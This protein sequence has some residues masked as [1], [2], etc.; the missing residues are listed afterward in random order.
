[1]KLLSKILGIAGKLGIG[2]IWKPVINIVV[3]ALLCLLVWWGVNAAWNGVTY[4]NKHYKDLSFE[5][6][7]LLSENVRLK[8]RINRV[9]ITLDST[10][11]AKTADSVMLDGLIK[12]GQTVMQALNKKNK[13]L[14]ATVEKYRT[15]NRVCYEMVT[16]KEGLFKSRKEYREINCPDL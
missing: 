5:N 10:R 3:F 15:E 12:E 16:V 1:M 7:E 8:E 9:V 6:N 11:Q 4:A 14:T 2:G 13:E